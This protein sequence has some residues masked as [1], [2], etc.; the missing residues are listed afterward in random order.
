MAGAVLAIGLLSSCSA[1]GES[2]TPD[3]QEP[4]TASAASEPA[5]TGEPAPSPGT[6]TATPEPTT[7]EP[8]T[9]EPT[10][11]E[12][13]PCDADRCFSVAATG[14]LL[15][16]PGLWE[17]AAAD[18]EAAGTGDLDFEPLLAGQR[19]YLDQADLGICHMET[20]VALPEGPFS[21][22]PQFNVP[23]QI[24]DAARDVGYDAC[25]TASNH[26]IDAGT[27]GLNR[28]LD[29]LDGLGLEHTGSYADEESSGD[30]MILE[31]PAARVA[32]IQATYGLNGLIPE[33]PWQVDLID[34]AVMTEKARQARD[35]GADV[36]IAV[37]HAGDEY[38]TVPNAQQ[39]EV[40]H[41]LADSGEVDFIYGHHTHSVLPIEKYNDTWIVYGLGNGVSELSP[42]YAVNNEGLMVRAQFAQDDGG[43]WTVS[44]L[45]WV[46]SIIVADPYRWC[47]LAPEQPAGTCTAPDRE[48]EVSGRIAQVV[49]TFGAVDDG[50]HLWDLTDDQ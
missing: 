7:P 28:T 42:T 36:V 27:E 45:A 40:A 2:P 48:A 47:A 39:V 33:Q 13:P 3:G 23:P 1:P 9:P 49:D 8:T 30:V 18:G 10:P 15:I 26:T 46:P 29:V 44:D 11:G 19:G 5:A 6:D 14:D 35:E 4:T 24:L 17:Q 21:G 25:T 32:V 31:T 20:P 37:I 16:H 41:A 34:A 22:Y 12:G 38:A 43:D 50:A